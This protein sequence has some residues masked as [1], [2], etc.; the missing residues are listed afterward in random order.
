MSRIGDDEEDLRGARDQRADQQEGPEV[1]GVH[2]AGRNRRDRQQCRRQDA[3]AGDD[4]RPD[5]GVAAALQAPADDDGEDPEQHAGERSE[6]DGPQGLVSA[7]GR[8][9]DAHGEDHL[10]APGRQLGRGAR[11]PR[12]PD[13]PG[14]RDGNDGLP[15]VRAARPRPGRGH[16]R[17]LRRPQRAAVRQQESRGPRVPA[18]LGGAVRRDL[19]TPRQRDRALS[20]PRAVRAA[21]LGARRR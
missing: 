14:G 2:V 11:P 17:L 8:A 15:P 9:E 12:R 19:L 4:H 18:Q 5:L 7:R 10:R 20:P 1:A 3:D 13:P 16:D 21:G 6:E